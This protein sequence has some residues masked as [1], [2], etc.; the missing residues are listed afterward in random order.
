MVFII[1]SRLLK[2]YSKHNTSNLNNKENTLKILSN[3]LPNI[4]QY[5]CI[6]SSRISW[7]SS[8][9]M[10][11]VSLINQKKASKSINSNSKN[12]NSQKGL[13]PKKKKN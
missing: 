12:K 4:I 10:A 1:F 7:L 11:F 5:L 13:Q 9:S 6:L 2:Y 3:R 8:I